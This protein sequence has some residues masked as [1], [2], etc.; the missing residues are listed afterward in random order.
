MEREIPF[1]S[2]DGQ[3][4]QWIDAKRLDRLISLDR[5]SRVVKHR[6]GHA[7]RAVLRHTPGEPKPKPSL[8]SDYLGTEY[9]LRQR[10]E[11]GRR[12]FRLRPLGERDADEHYLAPD[13]VGPIFLR[14]LLDWKLPA[15]IGF[16]GHEP[17]KVTDRTIPN[18][19]LYP[20]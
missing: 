12:C 14:V 20:Y 5:V 19:P 3:L 6:K 7:A 2:Y 13:E 1:Y 9:C 11:D 8:L 15:G 4:L 10:L 17:P 16:I 18:K